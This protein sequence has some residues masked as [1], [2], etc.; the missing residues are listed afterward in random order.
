M[1]QN[2]IDNS[3]LSLVWFADISEGTDQ[4]ASDSGIPAKCTYALLKLLFMGVATSNEHA[5]G[6][7][8]CTINVSYRYDFVSTSGLSAMEAQ[9]SA[10]RKAIRAMCGIE[11]KFMQRKQNDELP[12]EFGQHVE[13]YVARF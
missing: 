5:N 10:A 11:N 12:P 4:G 13:T 7:H 2:D 6:S 8:T 3:C 1:A 9:N